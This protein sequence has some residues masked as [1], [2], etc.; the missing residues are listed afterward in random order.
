MGLT[1]TNKIFNYLTN[2]CL[3]GGFTLFSR[4]P[5]LSFLKACT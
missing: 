3:V 1:N 2:E 5:Y 4:M